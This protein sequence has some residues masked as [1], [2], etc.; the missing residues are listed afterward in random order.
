MGISDGKNVQTGIGEM[1]ARAS[2]E[3]R[4]KSLG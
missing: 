3:K 1:S 4:K 2:V